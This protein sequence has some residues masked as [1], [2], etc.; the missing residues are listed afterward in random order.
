[1]KHEVTPRVSLKLERKAA[2]ALSSAC[3]SGSG[4]HFLSALSQ[5]ACHTREVWLSSP[6]WLRKK[7]S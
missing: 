6:L 1:M 7:G 4:N 5:W 2:G 3:C